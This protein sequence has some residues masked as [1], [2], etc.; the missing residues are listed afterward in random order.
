MAP[1]KSL[2]LLLLLALSASGCSM[3]SKTSKEERA[4]AK[5][6]S[7]TSKHRDQQRSKII[8]Q[9]A[10]MPRLRPTPGPVQQSVQTSEGE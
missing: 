3:F 7:K 10:E 2:C 8:Q 9:R 1:L 4:Y 5:Y 6:V